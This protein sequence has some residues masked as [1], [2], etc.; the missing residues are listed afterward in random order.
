[1]FLR[2]SRVKIEYLGERTTSLCTGGFFSPSFP[3]IFPVRRRRGRFLRS[4]LPRI[5]PRKKIAKDPQGRWLL[6][7]PRTPTVAPQ[8]HFSRY[9]ACSPVNSHTR[10]VY[11]AVDCPVSRARVSFFLLNASTFLPVVLFSFSPTTSQLHPADVPPPNDVTSPVFSGR[12]LPG[13]R[14]E[15]PLARMR[16]RQI[17][18]E[19]AEEEGGAVMRLFKKFSLSFSLSS[20][21]PFLFPFDRAISKVANSRT[22]V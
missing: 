19:F 4:R 6:L 5:F 16:P 21:S 12:K 17:S 10:R 1:M 15:D 8:L 9:R 18:F 20:S 3:G 14:I 2:T 11:R 7:L 13:S 22:S